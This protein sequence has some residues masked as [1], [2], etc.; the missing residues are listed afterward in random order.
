[1]GIFSWISQMSPQNVKSVLTKERRRE[2]THTEEG[3]QRLG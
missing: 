3:R 2:M 1:M